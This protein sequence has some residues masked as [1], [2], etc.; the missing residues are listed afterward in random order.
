[1]EV[2]FLA[3]MRIEVGFDQGSS[4]NGINFKIIWRCC[5]KNESKTLMMKMKALYHPLL[6]LRM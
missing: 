2:A 6:L 1:M 5:D 4:M 3:S